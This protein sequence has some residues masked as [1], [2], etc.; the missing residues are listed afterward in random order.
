MFE[1]FLFI[2]LFLGG[3]LI[4]EMVADKVHGPGRYYIVMNVEGDV[5]R[6]EWLARQLAKDKK[7]KIR[8]IEIRTDKPKKQKRLFRRKRKDG[9][10]PKREGPPHE[11]DPNTPY[12]TIRNIDGTMG[13]SK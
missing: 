1:W 12:N 7:I 3:W 2:S 9:G 10:L 4:Y 5:D 6:V 11:E 8:S 13:T